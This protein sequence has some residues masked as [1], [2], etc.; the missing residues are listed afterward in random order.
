M[1]T[2]SE[3]MVP[4]LADDYAAFLKFDLTKEVRKIENVIDYDDK[5]LTL[6]YNFFT[7]CIFKQN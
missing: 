5:N 7:M 4:E 1:P 6:T 2:P 3:K